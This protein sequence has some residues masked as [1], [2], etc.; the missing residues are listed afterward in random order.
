MACPRPCLAADAMSVD[1]Y[2]E[3][4]GAELY[5]GFCRDLGIVP[6]EYW[7]WVDRTRVKGVDWWH[8]DLELDDIKRWPAADDYCMLVRVAHPDEADGPQRLRHY[9]SA[10]AEGLS[11]EQ[12]HDMMWNEL[13][14]SRDLTWYMEAMRVFT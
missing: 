11:A 14:G 6:M 3:Y 12:I 1:Q 8:K 13:G 10:R 2:L 7:A 5:H 4:W 9:A